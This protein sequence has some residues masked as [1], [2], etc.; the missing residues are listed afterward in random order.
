[1]KKKEQ[2]LSLREWLSLAGLTCAAFV[3]H[4]SEFSPIGLLTDIAHD[5]GKTEAGAGLL[6]SVYAWVVTVLSLPLMLLVSR[7]DLRRLLLWVVALFAAF[8]CVS[9][10]SSSFA[11]L[12][13]SRI[14][15]A[16]THS[17]FWSI[18]APIAVR[19]VP[20]RCRSLALGTVVTGSSL[21]II[22]GLPLGRVIGLQV[23]WRITFLC[24]G[25]VAL[26]TLIWLMLSLPALPSRGRFS[27]RKLPQLFG[28]ST[29]AGLYLFTFLVATAYYTCYSYIEPFFKQVAGMSDQIVTAALIFF[30]CAGLVGSMLFSKFY[31][32]NRYRFMGCVLVVLSCSLLLLQPLSFGVVPSIVLCL[33][34]G[35]CV[36]AY[37]VSMQSEII[38]LSPPEA[39]AVSMSIFSG[40]F[41][42]GIGCGALAGGFVCS[43]SSIAYIG[44]A[45][46]LIA[47]GALAYWL[48][49]LKHLVRA[50]YDAGRSR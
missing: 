24:I 1:M 44:F 35:T 25:A 50:S 37:N 15:V 4:T 46:G 19:V 36:T 38:S 5:F 43:H 40:I 45:G 26:L 12:M 6:I 8:Q 9:W 28:N 3:F 21:A 16:C 10:L 17:I 29:L 33:F 22:L 42:L 34:W 13:M 32:L 14:G 18:V 30:G 20:D 7:M 49:R 47:L 31:M 2:G 41:N 39:T 11:M 27:V 23:G 48:F